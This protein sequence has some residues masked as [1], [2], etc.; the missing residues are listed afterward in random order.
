M[1]SL[2]PVPSVAI[3]VNQ[4]GGQD[5]G[6]LTCCF[7]TCQYQ[8]DRTLHPEPPM[9]SL[10]QPRDRSMKPP[11]KHMTTIN[12][13]P[14]APCPPPGIH[15]AVPAALI[16]LH[17]EDSCYFGSSLGLSSTN[18]LLPATCSSSL[19]LSTQLSSQSVSSAHPNPF[20]ATH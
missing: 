6:A 15:T 17:I 19:S 1:A 9:F 3:P 20:R 4:G 18:S 13:P 7:R 11:P 14:P 10:S 5:V 2:L 12:L 16:S 8:C